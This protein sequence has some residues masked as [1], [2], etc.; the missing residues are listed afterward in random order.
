MSDI[1][2]VRFVEI[3]QLSLSDAAVAYAV[4][5]QRVFPC[6]PG[7]KRPLTRHGFHDASTDPDRVRAWWRACPDANVGLVTGETF[8]VVDVDV[9]RRGSG[10]AAFEEAERGGLAAGWALLVRTPSGGLHAYYPA[11][12]ANRCWAVSSAHID[13]RARGGFVVGVP[14]RAADQAHGYEVIATGRNP[15][16]LDGD[17]LRRSLMPR[18]TGPSVAQAA[19]RMAWSPRAI[20]GMSA[21]V[22]A[23][24][25]GNR[26]RGLY[27]AACRF[28]ER[29]LSEEAAHQR[30]GAA[31]RDAGLAD[32]EVS[33]TIRSAYRNADVTGLPN[34][35]P[36]SSMRGLVR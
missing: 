9:R 12:P 35:P 1:N 25:E 2:D 29:G 30:L 11:D 22:R 31:A 10:V 26:N 36:M 4:S 19:G 8:D 14:S 33:A 5:G 13:M 34:A 18:Q 32:R 27:W 21:W 3:A 7:G 20:D 24:P 23:Q 16:A 6:T 17:A 15:H 28:R